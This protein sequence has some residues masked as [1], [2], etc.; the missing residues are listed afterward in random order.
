MKLMKIK[1]SL[2]TVLAVAAAFALVSCDTPSYPSSSSADSAELESYEALSISA[3]TTNETAASLINSE[4]F[5]RGVDISALYDLEKNGAVFYNSDDEEEDMLSILKANG[6]NTVRIRLWN[7]PY[8]A[9]SKP[10][11]PNYGYNTLAKAKSMGVRAK[12]LGL[13]VLLDFHY[14]DTWTHPGQ[15]LYPSAWDNLTTI[16]EVESAVSEYTKKCISYLSEAGAAPDFVQIGNEID[17]G[18]LLQKST[19][20][21]PSVS[22]EDANVVCG[23]GSEELA[24]VLNA[25]GAAVKSVDSSIEVMIHVANPSYYSRI[26]NL[27]GLDS[28]NYDAIGVS[29]YPCNSNRKISDLKNAISSIVSAGKKAYVAETSFPWT[30]EWVEGKNDDKNNVIWYTG[31]DSMAT[32]YE[33]LNEDYNLTNFGISKSTYNGSPIIAPTYQNQAAVI[34]EVIAAVAEAGGSGIYYWGGEWVATTSIPSTWENQTLFDLDGKVLPSAKVFSVKAET[35][36]SLFDVVPEEENT[37]SAEKTKVFTGTFS[38][39]NPVLIVNSDDISKLTI[40][41]IKISI[42]DY[43]AS[44]NPWITAYA[45]EGDWPSGDSVQWTGISDGSSISSGTEWNDAF[46]GNVKLYGLKVAGDSGL[47]ATVTVTYTE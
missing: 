8:N 34:R 27:S 2:A 1:K 6:V 31:T 16:D 3:I 11:L 30:C 38:S 44:E 20:T 39:G 21:N 46:I 29:F 12:A 41:K 13:K 28:A 32:A 43:T 17:S 47:S 24:K 23:N 36:T 42:S 4:S 5:I 37:D 15:Q 14:S 26:T 7:D 25:A 45:G 10:S 33:N 35:G 19:N 18:M 9:N 22:S 40:T